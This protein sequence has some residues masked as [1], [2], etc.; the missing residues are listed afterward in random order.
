MMAS[1]RCSG[2]RMRGKQL[3]LTSKPEDRHDRRFQPL[4]HCESDVRRTRD[5]RSREPNF[6]LEV[7][8]ITKKK[9]SLTF[10]TFS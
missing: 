3:G 6:D 8:A 10:C 7:P 4:P 1:F 9:D 2:Q 5:Q